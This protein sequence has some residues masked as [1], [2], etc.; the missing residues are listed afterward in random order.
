MNIYINGLRDREPGETLDQA[1]LFFI[2]QTK[3]LPLGDAR[4]NVILMIVE[5]YLEVSKDNYH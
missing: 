5:A 4:N 1:F 3:I 2:N